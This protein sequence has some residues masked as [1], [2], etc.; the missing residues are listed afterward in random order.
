MGC[1]SFPRAAR[2][3]RP[4][5]FAA[6]RRASRRVGADHFHAE[7]APRTSSGPRL[8]M[9]VSKRVSKRAVE[10]NRIKRQIR[11]SYRH[12]RLQLPALDILVVARTSASTCDNLVLR[13]DLARLWDKLRRLA[14]SASGDDRVEASSRGRHNGAVPAASGRITPSPSPSSD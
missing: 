3:L 13:A 7:A 6:L 8:G 9:A 12:I 14:A 5:D 11:E 4:G 10:R 2:L 1:A